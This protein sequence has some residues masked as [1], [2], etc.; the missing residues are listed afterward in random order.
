MRHCGRAPAP[1]P[2]GGQKP[3]AQSRASRAAAGQFVQ[4]DRLFTVTDLYAE[5]DTG[6]NKGDSV[7]ALE[8]KGPI[9]NARMVPF[10]RRYK[11]AKPTWNSRKWLY[12]VIENRTMEVG[13]A[14]AVKEWEDKLTAIRQLQARVAIKAAIST[15]CRQAKEELCIALGRLEP[16]EAQKQMRTRIFGERLDEGEGEGKGEDRNDAEGEDMEMDEEEA[17]EAY[18]LVHARC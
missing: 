6:I 4:S 18:R 15:L 16:E 17:G 2:A 1:R 9:H 7:R 11:Q 14:D 8:A 12:Y 13:K 5:W 10:W 3:K